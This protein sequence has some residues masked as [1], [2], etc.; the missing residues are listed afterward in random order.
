LTYNVE[1]ER[2]LVRQLHV[3]VSSNTSMTS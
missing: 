2:R 1:E 3:S